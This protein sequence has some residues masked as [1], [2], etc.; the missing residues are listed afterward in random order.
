MN[1]RIL[2]ILDPSNSQSSVPKIVTLVKVV[3]N[4]LSTGKGGPILI[5]TLGIS[6]PRAV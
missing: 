6:P 5:S 2:F 4:L 1:P 3:I